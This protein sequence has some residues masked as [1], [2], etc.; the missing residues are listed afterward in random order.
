VKHQ[1]DGSGDP[2]EDLGCDQEELDEEG[3][4]GEYQ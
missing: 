2:V 3:L 1:E 4:G